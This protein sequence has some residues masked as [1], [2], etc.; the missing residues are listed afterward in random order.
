[1]IYK[2][3]WQKPVCFSL[4]K[5]AVLSSTFSVFIVLGIYNFDTSTG[6]GWILHMTSC[7]LF[8]L[9]FPRNSRH[10]V[11]KNGIYAFEVWRWR[12]WQESVKKVIITVDWVAKNCAP[13]STQQKFCSSKIAA[14]F[15]A[16]FLALLSLV[17]RFSEGKKLCWAFVCKCARMLARNENGIDL[18][19]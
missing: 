11:K 2:Q 17:E 14:V 18:F 8:T 9:I 12:F 5:T 15:I 7:N 4:A 1:M 6:R 10:N 3:V 16:K 19:L 13:A